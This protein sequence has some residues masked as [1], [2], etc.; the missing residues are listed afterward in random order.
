MVVGPHQY[1]VECRKKASQFGIGKSISWSSQENGENSKMDFGLFVKCLPAA[2]TKI[3]NE[4][5]TENWFPKKVIFKS[6]SFLDVS[7]QN[8]HKLE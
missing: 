6:F 4:I 8:I 5:N 3:K 2:G 7:K 1:K